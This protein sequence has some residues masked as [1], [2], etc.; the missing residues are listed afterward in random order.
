[1]KKLLLLCTIVFIGTVNTHAQTMAKNIDAKTFTELANTKISVIDVRTADEVKQ[2]KL[3]Q[4]VNIDVFTADFEA[5]VA[6]QHPNKNEPIYLYCRS[7]KR[8]ANAIKKLEAVGY[9]NLINVDG[10]YLAIEAVK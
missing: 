4:A 5:E 7:G 3:E 10:G 6:K 9:T 8:S 1:M 2:G